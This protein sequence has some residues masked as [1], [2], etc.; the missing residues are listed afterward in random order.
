MMCNAKISYINQFQLLTC[1]TFLLFSFE[2]RNIENRIFL[3][4]GGWPVV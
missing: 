3:G 2:H 4:G 1:E